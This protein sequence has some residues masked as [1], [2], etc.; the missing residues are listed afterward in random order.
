MHAGTN[1]ATRRSC[2]SYKAL[3]TPCIVSTSHRNWSKVRLGNWSVGCYQRA[4]DTCFDM[5]QKMWTHRR[6]FILIAFIPCYQWYKDVLLMKRSYL[7]IIYSTSIYLHMILIILSISHNVLFQR[8][9]K[10]SAVYFIVKI[11]WKI[12]I[13]INK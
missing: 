10:F 5:T 11:I 4:P 1:P 6:V 12:R 13:I 8:S 9:K 3:T 2:D 7:S